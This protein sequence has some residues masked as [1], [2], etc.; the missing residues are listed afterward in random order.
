MLRGGGDNME[1]T[2]NDNQP[3]LA[4]SSASACSAAD[5]RKAVQAEREA[6][7][8]LITSGNYCR[9]VEHLQDMCECES[10]AA[11]IRARAL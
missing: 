9:R 4:Q 5:V 7:I 1:E 8:E 10:I 3:L 6:I 11:D 2:I